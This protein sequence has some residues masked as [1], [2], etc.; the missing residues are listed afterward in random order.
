MRAW[1]LV[2][3]AAVLARP[4]KTVDNEDFG[5]KFPIWTV[6]SN[7]GAMSCQLA[8]QHASGVWTLPRRLLGNEC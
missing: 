7:T 3:V 4:I 2:L 6:G 8:S 5:V 1:L